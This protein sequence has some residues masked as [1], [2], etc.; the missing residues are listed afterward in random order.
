[1]A[2]N[3]VTGTQVEPTVAITGTE[4]GACRV[5]TGTQYA[6]LEQ[7]EELCGE[8]APEVPAKVAVS[9]TVRGHIV[10]GTPVTVTAKVTGAEFGVCERVTGTEYVDPYVVAEECGIAPE[11]A[12]EKVTV[13]PTD[14]GLPVTGADPNRA[15]P[16]TGGEEGATRRVTGSQYQN[17]EWIRGITRNGTSVP[18]KVSVMSTVRGRPV[19]G[20]LVSTTPKIT[21]A[22]RG[23][24]VEVT[25]TE[26]EDSLAKYQA[27]NRKPLPSTEKVTVA[28]T[29]R[30]QVVTGTGLEH[31]PVV[32]GDDAGLCEDVTGTPYTGPNEYAQFCA[33]DELPRAAELPSGAWS[34]SG[35]AV[36]GNGKVTGAERGAS[37]AI[38]GTPYQANPRRYGGGMDDAPRGF[39]IVSPAAAARGRASKRITGT[40]WGSAG[41]RIT[42]PLNLAPGLVSGT[43][44][45]RYG[46]DEFDGGVA[47]TGPQVT[48]EGREQ[49]F[50][51]TG[52]AWGR[53]E[54]ITG[55]EG[56]SAMRNPTLRGTGRA[57]R[58][59]AREAAPE[60]G[61]ASTRITGSA[62]GVSQGPVVTFSGGSRG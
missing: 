31:S 44:E 29:W 46:D 30:G 13:S 10:T 23:E 20:T 57:P 8:P 32:T 58:P 19:T 6:G 62:G 38:S 27:C 22:E 45:F 37:A 25:G 9:S 4:A 21:G 24:C 48:G 1:L 14:L 50:A 53:S 12:P 34:V 47:W 18:H 61:P 43:P 11:P 51:I 40:G 7:Y 28:A 16:V 54:R 2:G 49:G 3:L 15:A 60:A 17:A 5:V 59:M 26:Y 39:S 33:T 52:D 42:G 41:Q 35:T 55:T 56:A 36:V